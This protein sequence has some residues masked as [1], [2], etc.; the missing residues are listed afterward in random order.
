MKEL[1]DK[2][3]TYNIF[4][5][6]FPGIIFVIILKQCSNYNFIQDD[7]VTG[8]FLYYFIGLVIS[9]IGSLLI[10]PILKKTRFLKFTEY[11]SFIKASKN[12]PKIDLFSE[13]N[14]MYR[15]ICSMFLLLLAFRLFD[16]IEKEAPIIKSWNIEILIII[17]FCLFIFSYRKQTKYV[18]DRVEVNNEE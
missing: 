10:E 17:L 14:N 11:K 7:I 12:D 3:S 8:V 6:L 1:I 18:K 15:T 16:F 4:N 5:Y 2:L 13:I 9:R